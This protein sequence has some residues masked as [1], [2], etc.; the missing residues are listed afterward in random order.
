MNTDSPYEVRRAT[1]DDATALALLRHEFRSGRAELVEDKAAFL[2]R[3]EAWMREHL[4]MHDRWRAWLVEVDGAVVGNVWLQIIEKVPNPGAEQERHAY[5]TNFFVRPEFRG[6][7]AGAALLSLLQLECETFNV[8]TIFL[9]PTA[10]SR[11]LYARHGFTSSN[12]VLT[13]KR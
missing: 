1:R 11:P 4:P 2:I 13:L 8:D 7:G 5:V 12:D 6:A 9:W 10:Q 3:A